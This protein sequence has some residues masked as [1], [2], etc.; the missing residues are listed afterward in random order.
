[1]K[2]CDVIELDVCGKLSIIDIMII[3]LGNLKCY[4]L[5][6]VENVMVEVKKV[7]YVFGS[8][9]GKEIGEWVLVDFGD[10]I[11]YVM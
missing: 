2:G 7:G 6:I 8:V 11:L 4:V 10:V 3:C 9:E 1:M 5:F